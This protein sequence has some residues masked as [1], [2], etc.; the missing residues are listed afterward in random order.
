MVYSSEKY[1]IKHLTLTGALVAMTV[2]LRESEKWYTF[3]S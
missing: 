1:V 2:S 3:N